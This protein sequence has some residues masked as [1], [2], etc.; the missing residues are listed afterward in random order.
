QCAPDAGPAEVADLVGGAPGR[1]LRISAKT[2]EGVAEILDAVVARIPP[3]EGDP[4]ASARALVFDCS[5]DQYL[6]VVAFV[7]AVDGSFR[8]RDDLR[9]MAAGTRFEAEELGFFS[10]GRAP[11]DTLAAGGGGGGV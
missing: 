7:R 1:V 9:A 3:P 2:G 11:T 4:D 5:Y 8:T 10:P 6:G